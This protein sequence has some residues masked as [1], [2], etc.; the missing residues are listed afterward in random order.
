M[1]PFQLLL[2]TPFS[3]LKY[4]T[5]S[6]GK[7][8]ENALQT[9]QPEAFRQVMHIDLDLQKTFRPE[10]STIYHYGPGIMK[11]CAD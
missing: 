10:Q 1:G 4:P 5:L 6:V 7:S 3:F 11:F 9:K 2:P 8:S